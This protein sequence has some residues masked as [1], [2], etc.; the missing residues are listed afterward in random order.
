MPETACAREVEFVAADGKAM[1]ATWTTPQ[2]GARAAIAC[3]HGLTLTR[4]IFADLAPLVA[5]AG[6]GC[7]SVDLRG[8]GGSDGALREQGFNDQISDVLSSHAFLSQG[9]G[10][11]PARRGLLGFSLGGAVTLC[12]LAATLPARVALWAPLLKT[13]PWL[14]ARY[15]TYGKPVAGVTKIWD[16][17][18]VSE[19]LFDEAVALN[20]MAEAIAWPG[21]LFLGHG[22]R[23]RNHPPLASQEVAAQRIADGRE[24]DFYFPSRSGHLFQV[25]DER[26]ELHRRTVAYF[27][28]LNEENP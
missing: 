14:D 9:L 15:S 21:P 4:A 16:G 2:A 22:S 18:E 10:V 8:H 1:R 23:D 25:V 13:K 17:I 27:S 19:R 3:F 12:A 26:A 11:D 20:P 7:L 6:L 24:T 28:K 5:A